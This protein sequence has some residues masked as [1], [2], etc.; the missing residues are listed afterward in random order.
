MQTL[1][2]ELFSTYYKDVYVYLYSLTHDASLAEDLASDV[3]L[4][5]VK[6]ISTFRGESDIKTWLFSIARHKCFAYFRQKKRQL[7]VEMLGEFCENYGK[8]ENSLAQVEQSYVNK[9]VAKRIYELL[10][11][12]AERTR[13]IVLMRIEGFSFYEIGQKYGISESSARVID[14]RAK[15]KIRKILKEEGFCDE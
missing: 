1:L 2:K 4:E 12:E 15:A 7:E 14:F 13:N 8:Y 6:S 3:F 9:I 11:L 10:N 5:V